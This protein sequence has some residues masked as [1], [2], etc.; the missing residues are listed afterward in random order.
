MATQKNITFFFD[1]K[2]LEFL[3]PVW[4]D[5]VFVPLASMNGSRRSGTSLVEDPY[6]SNAKKPLRYEKWA[7]ESLK[8]GRVPTEMDA[9]F[10][11]QVFGVRKVGM[12]WF[13]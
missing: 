9:S 3:Y 1:G 7:M 13:S 6:V 4:D 5:V 2:F 12:G 11:T 10:C 8:R